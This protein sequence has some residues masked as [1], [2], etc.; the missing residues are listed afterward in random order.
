MTPSEQAQALS[1]REEL[2]F[3][4]TNRVSRHALSHFMGW[5]SK[6]RSPLLARCALVVWRC[7]DND[8]R[9]HEAAQSSF[10]SI[11]EIFTRTLK[12][13]ARPLDQQAA[14][15]LSPCDGII[16]E[17][18]A[19]EAG[20]VYQAKGYPYQLHELLGNAEL[21]QK[22]EGGTFVT[23]RLKSSMYHRFHAPRDC[24]LEQ[25]IYISGDRWNVHPPALRRIERLYCKNERA[26]V[27][28]LS[29]PPSA[30]VCLVAIAAILVSGIRVHGFEHTPTADPSGARVY[31]LHR[32]LQHGEEM[33][34]FEHGSTIVLLAQRG[35]GLKVGL[36]PGTRI[37]MGQALL[38]P[39]STSA[40][41]GDQA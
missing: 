8:F 25:L 21:A 39:C 41:Q 30:D 15:I 6:I 28:C 37:F 3:L 10:G 38:E 9:L 35:F 4:L 7:F 18:G 32:Q 29:D 40:G 27:E 24:R 13:G 17:C 33:G 31:P 34:W 14:A 16:G 19:I 1:W 12:P 11:H 20:R 36:Q 2:V 23:L 22:Y 5:L 26:V